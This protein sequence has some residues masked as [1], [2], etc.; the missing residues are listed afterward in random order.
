MFN[1]LLVVSVLLAATSSAAPLPVVFPRQSCAA[2]TIISAR[3]STQAVGEGSM[4]TLAAAIDAG[5]TATVNRLALAYPA[6]LSNYASS[7]ATGTATLKTQLT[8]LVASCPS[9]KI[10]LLGYSQGAHVIGDALGGGGGGSLG[11]KTAAISSTIG[12]HVAAIVQYG[13]PRHTSDETYHVGT[14][15]GS[16]LFPRLSDQRLTSYVSRARTYCDNGDPFCESGGD[17]TAHSKYPATYDSA[18]AQFVLSL[19]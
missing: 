3:G 6:T 10:V 8:N 2:I 14:S 18:A 15:D 17:L 1:F 16:G 13:D 12:A 4:A 9:T 7:S 19:L 5:T 11:T